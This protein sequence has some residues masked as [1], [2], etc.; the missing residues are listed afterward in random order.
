VKQFMRNYLKAE[1]RDERGNTQKCF[2]PFWGFLFCF[3]TLFLRG[4]EAKQRVRQPLSAVALLTQG[5]A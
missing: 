2:S 3:K 1:S 4:F 5:R